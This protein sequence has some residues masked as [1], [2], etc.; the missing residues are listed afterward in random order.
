MNSD[1]TYDQEDHQQDQ[2][3]DQGQETGQKIFNKGLEP[4]LFIKSPHGLIQVDQHIYPDQED[5]HTGNTTEPYLLDYILQFIQE[6]HEQD[7]DKIG[8]IKMNGENPMI[9]I[10]I[11]LMPEIQY[12]QDQREEGKGEK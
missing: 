3:Y 12:I 1:R 2:I 6:Y 10:I 9:H 7:K 4:A 5:Q 8:A 11:L